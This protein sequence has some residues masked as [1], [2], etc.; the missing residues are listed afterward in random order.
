MQAGGEAVKVGELRRAHK[1]DVVVG[2]V[3]LYAV[4]MDALRQAETGKG[5]DRHQLGGEAFEEQPICEITRR[6]GL[7]FP[8]GQ[9]MKKCDEASRMSSGD[10][11]RELL[12]KV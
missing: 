5:A 12:G 1:E 9:V 7:G 6:V 8:L 4:L 11:E 3:E 10:A 2:Y